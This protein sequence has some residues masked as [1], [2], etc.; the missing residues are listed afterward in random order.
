MGH[1]T[2]LENFS[3]LFTN[4]ILSQSW[5]QNI[6]LSQDTWQLL[7]G[8]FLI[9]SIALKKKLSLP[10]LPGASMFYLSNCFACLTA[11]FCSTIWPWVKIFHDALGVNSGMPSLDV[12]LGTSNLEKKS[13]RHLIN[14]REPALEIPQ[15]VENIFDQPNNLLLTT[16]NWFLANWK[17]QQISF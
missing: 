5:C 9:W 17:N 6:I 7:S 15:G 4:K 16:K 1:T 8:V 14:P 11:F 10:R 12:L 3:N 2:G 13:G